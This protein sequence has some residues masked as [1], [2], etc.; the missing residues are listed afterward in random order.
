MTLRHILVPMLGVV[1]DT[2]A[3]STAFGIA[4]TVGAHVE[5]LFPAMDPRQA[6][7]YGGY[8]SPFILDRIMKETDADNARRREQTSTLF[9]KLVREHGVH[10]RDQPGTPGQA[11]AAYLE[12]IGEPNG[13]VVDAGRLSDLIIIELLREDK[14]IEFN[15]LLEV[16]LR[17]TGKPVLLVPRA[18]PSGFAKTIAIA[19]NGSVQATRAVGFAMPLLERASNVVVLTV[20]GERLFGP[21]AKE[22][23]AALS[24]H[25]V[26]ASTC[27]LP[28]SDQ[29]QGQALLTAAKHNSADLMVLGAYT[30]GELRR[31][32]FGGVTGELLAK[33]PL[34]L[35]MAH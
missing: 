28:A 17:D 11:S 2:P 19:W 3:L 34:P 4:K 12:R 7:A 23:A 24:W 1:D 35:L 25:G 32:L 9:A 18:M 16:V 33:S 22:L 30:H 21:T 13:L 26:A 15:P 6:A 27:Q 5:A 14:Q 29:A 10:L 31:L 20:E 8:V